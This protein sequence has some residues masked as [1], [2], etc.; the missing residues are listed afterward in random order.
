MHTFNEC[1]ERVEKK[2]IFFKLKGFWHEQSRADRDDNVYIRW[3]NINPSMK[4]NFNKYTLKQV[5]HL[6]APYDTCSVMHYSGTA[7]SRVYISDKKR[8]GS[9]RNYVVKNILVHLVTNCPKMGHK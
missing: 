3:E 5:Q 7:F 1:W 8:L 2:L 6:N 4:Y 9:F